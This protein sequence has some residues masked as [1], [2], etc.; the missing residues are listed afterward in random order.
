MNAA[1]KTLL[2]A[3]WIAPMNGAGLI[4]RG[5]VVIVDG[6]ILAVGLADHLAQTHPDATLDDLGA[7]ILLP[8][9]VNAHVH[10]EL[11]DCSCGSSP[12]GGF[13]PWLLQLVRRHF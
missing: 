8:G 10:L 1:S 7:A 12:T 2:R 13:A 3:D 4:R 11:S 5:G 9:L 6:R